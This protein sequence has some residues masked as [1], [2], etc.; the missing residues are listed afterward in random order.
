MKEEV[1][2]KA[3]AD[4]REERRGGRIPFAPPAESYCF[5]AAPG[6]VSLFIRGPLSAKDLSSYLL[7][8]SRALHRVALKLA[9]ER[10]S[11]EIWFCFGDDGEFNIFYTRVK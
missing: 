5:P 4:L 6:R 3:G 8:L 9:S 11:A 1:I 7:E 10:E 2:E